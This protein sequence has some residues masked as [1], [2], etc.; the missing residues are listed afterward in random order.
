MERKSYVS[1]PAEIHTALELRAVHGP[2]ALDVSCECIRALLRK[3][4]AD[5]VLSWL[6]IRNALLRLL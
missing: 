4:D 5:A 2:S 3:S 1:Q 6:E